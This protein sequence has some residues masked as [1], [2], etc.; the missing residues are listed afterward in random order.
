MVIVKNVMQYL[1]LPRFD[2]EIDS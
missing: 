2:A 1:I